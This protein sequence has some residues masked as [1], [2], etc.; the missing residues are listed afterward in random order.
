MLLEIIFYPTSRGLRE[1]FAGETSEYH[2]VLGPWYFA[3]CFSAKLRKEQ[4]TKD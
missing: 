2:F 3:L 1:N 4:S